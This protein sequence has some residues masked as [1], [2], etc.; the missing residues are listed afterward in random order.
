MSLIRALKQRQLH[1]PFTTG[2]GSFSKKVVP[3]LPP[4]CHHL[5]PILPRPLITLPNFGLFSTPSGPSLKLFLTFSIPGS[6]IRTRDSYHVAR[7]GQIDSMAVE[8]ATQS[9]GP[10]V[11]FNGDIDVNHNTP[12][13][14][15][16]ERVAELPV[17][18]KDGKPHAFKS[19]YGPI[20]NERSRTLIIFIRHFFC[21]VSIT[22]CE[23][24]LPEVAR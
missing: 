7:A 4:P 5:N 13:R 20:N 22:L 14:K 1:H 16:L 24:F 23:S 8:T 9:V 10:T 21:G 17:L 2:V 3:W 11:D 12:R 6:L 19:L 15:D 18:D